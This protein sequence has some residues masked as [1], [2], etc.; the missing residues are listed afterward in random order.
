M[1]RRSLI[2]LAFFLAA[3][4]L[5]A[6][7]QRNPA[8]APA[9]YQWSWD[10][11]DAMAPVGTF[12]ANLVPAGRFD[13]RYRFHQT[14]WQGIYLGTDTLSGND[15]ATL[16]SD[17][18]MTRRNEHHELQAMWGLSENVTIIARSEFIIIERE[19]VHNFRMGPSPVRTSVEELGDT[20]VGLLYRVVG[21]GPY[22]MHVQAGGVIPTGKAITY[23]DTTRAQTGAAVSL[24]Y[25]M[26]TGFG[27]FGVVLGIGGGVQNEVGSLGAQFRLRTDFGEND[28]GFTPGDQYEANGWAAYRLN[29]VFSFSAG[30]RWERY[31]SLDGL[32]E[33]LNIT[34]DP[35][36]AAPFLSGQ[37][38]HLPLGVNFR[39]PEGHRLAG[40]GLGVEA[41]YTL[42]HDMDAPQLGMNWG[43]NFA[44]TFGF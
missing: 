40:H 44:Y 3:A 21:E 10:R 19:T 14:N 43:F 11:P 29:D 25:D 39:L 1:V 18:P 28:A 2:A 9:E 8:S 30:I 24:P 34:G 37:R 13:L 4:P 20:E 17:V 41:V 42:H 33:S 16:Y 5:T 36:N 23:G 35:H 15:V 12:G 32:D 7:M 31:R 22:R 38:A 6:Q 26:R 27:T